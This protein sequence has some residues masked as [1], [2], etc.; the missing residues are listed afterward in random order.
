VKNASLTLQI[1]SD[2]EPRVATQPS[3]LLDDSVSTPLDLSRTD[4]VGHSS[5]LPAPTH[6]DDLLTAATRVADGAHT[7][8]AT[9][10]VD[11]AFPVCDVSA[12]HEAGL[13]TASLPRE[14]GGDGLA[15]A[16]L[17]AVLKKIG[18]GSLPLG[19]LYEG[20]VNA[21]AL[22]A[23]YGRPEQ[24]RLVAAEAS[25]GHLF[26]VW[27][28]DD[29]DGLH[30]IADRIQYRLEG[31]K[32][33]ASGAGHIERPIVTATDSEGKRLMVMP[34]MLRGERADL[35]SW[36]AQGMRASAT[37]AVDF[38]DIRIEP[39]QIIGGDGDYERQPTF[40]AGAWRFAA[41]QTG[42]MERL[43][44]LLLVH[45]RRTA[46]GADPHQ[47]ARLG[48]AA[49]AA[50]TA[51]LWVM[52]AADIAE[53]PF[54]TRPPD[55]IVAYVNLARLAVERAALDLLELV[56]RSVGLQGLMR[57]HP[58]ERVSRD[59]K[60]YLRQPGPDRALTSAAAW[61]LKNVAPNGEPWN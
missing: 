49:I 10:D 44:D 3:R 26:G 7:T 4:A 58:I 60:T 45:H 24:I 28:T 34:R 11:G 9:Y 32:I 40:S 47:A 57:P 6:H 8:A 1:K 38:S 33:L 23:R 19:R 15:G 37:G 2:I 42:G 16:C 18:Y 17:A 30:L 27:N 59:L 56:E 36:T 52:R 43:L 31:R 39:D 5:D 20:H 29:K 46:R 25:R 61:L 12:L 53:D 54:S 21:M 22:T 14:Y 35:S 51:N 13:M 48:Q 55:Q 50:E 41:V